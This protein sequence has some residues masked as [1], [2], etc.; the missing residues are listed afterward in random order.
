MDNTVPGL[1]RAL[2]VLGHLAHHPK[3][4]TPG[5]IGEASDVPKATLYRILR[6]LRTHGYIV[7]TDAPGAPLALGPEIRRLAACMPRPVDLL[8]VA[9]PVMERLSAHI[10]E[11]VKLVVREGRE[12]VTL[13]VANSSH[14]SRIAS[15][16]GTRLPL[17][18]GGTQR[19]LLAH[20]P[21]SVVDEVLS[22]PLER[23][24]SRTITDPE[25]IRRNLPRLR[26]DGWVGAHSEGVEGVGAFSAAV[27]D[28]GGKMVAAMVATYVHAGRTTAQRKHIADAVVA[29]AQDVSAQ[30]AQKE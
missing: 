23:R 9:R 24:A 13:A 8:E 25:D 19:L 4:L 29:A 18:L 21:A 16:V 3:G 27:T 22:Q 15:R 30:L 28:A 17:Y 2:W 5:D 10:G 7:G 6:V 12:A 26:R 1:E 20:A 11:T 14:D